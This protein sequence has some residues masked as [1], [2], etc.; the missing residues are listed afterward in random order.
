MIKEIIGEETLEDLQGRGQDVQ[1]NLHSRIASEFLDLWDVVAVLP[2]EPL[3]ARSFSHSQLGCHAGYW[4][5]TVQR[6]I[7][8]GGI[9]RK[10]I[11]FV[12]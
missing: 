12:L 5:V 8:G 11:Q 1:S 2:S 10:G 3:K 4:L 6:G 9:L 7:D